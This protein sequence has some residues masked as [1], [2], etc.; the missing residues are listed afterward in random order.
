MKGKRPFTDEEVS[1]LVREGFTGRYHLRDRAL[2]ALG[3]TTGF[4]VGTLL[5]IQLRHIYKDG[6]VVRNIS[7]PPSFFKR[8]S[9]GQAKR[10]SD[11][12]RQHLRLWIKELLNWEIYQWYKENGRPGDV[13]L[14]Q[15]Q[16][17]Y[18][19]AMS[20][21]S[22]RR[23]IQDA[24]KQVGVFDAAVS[25]HSMRKTAARRVLDFYTNE[26]REG[27]TTTNPVLLV[28]IF[29]G[30]KDPAATMDYL[31]FVAD[32]IPQELMDV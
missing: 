4:R 9:Q 7:L 14:F 31:S 27:R 1:L 19:E 17:G 21:T 20:Y 18:N 13:Y 24:A 11:N 29:L 6:V 28:Q 23:V 12:T 8:R 3:V 32:D 30:H 5:Q 15:S 25:T 22:A 10:L 2:F 16:E 26:F